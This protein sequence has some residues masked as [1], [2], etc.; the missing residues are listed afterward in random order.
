MEPLDELLESSGSIALLAGQLVVPGSSQ[1]SWKVSGTQP[2]PVLCASVTR[3]LRSC[4]VHEALTWAGALSVYGSFGE[5]DSAAGQSSQSV[6][7]RSPPRVRAVS[8]PHLLTTASAVAFVEVKGYAKLTG[9][10]PQSSRV[11]RL[12]QTCRSTSAAGS[13]ARSWCVVVCAPISCPAMRRSA[14]SSWERYP[15]WSI[16]A[17]TT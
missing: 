17:A 11:R 1:T 10:Y 2:P 5:K 6:G 16:H 7:E 13:W 14:R 3:S 9:S 8:N 4:S 12:L 15:G